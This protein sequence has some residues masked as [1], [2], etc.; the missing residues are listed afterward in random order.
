MKPTVNEFKVRIIAGLIF[1]LTILMIC[2]QCWP[3]SAI[4]VA[5]FFMRSGKFGKYSLLGIVSDKAIKFF[6]IKG[7]QIY[8]APKIFAARIGLVMSL[9]MLVFT[10]AGLPKVALAFG[11]TL[12]IFS[13][14][15]SAFGFCAGCVI[16]AY[17]V[18]YLKS[19]N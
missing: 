3:I 11:I 14:L 1:L 5:D 18:R 16:Y 2:R 9:M 4:L 13:F 6:K 17:L 10:L 12:A 19:A 7:Q 15:E 8:Y